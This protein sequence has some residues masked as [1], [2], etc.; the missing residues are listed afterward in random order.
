MTRHF[1]TTN[2]TSADDIG[3]GYATGDTWTNTV[4]YT[5]YEQVSDGVW[6]FISENNGVQIQGI[7]YTEQTNIP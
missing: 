1:K 6:E 5:R 4:T 3:A 7:D 2:P